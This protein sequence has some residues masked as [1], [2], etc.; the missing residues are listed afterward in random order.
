MLAN[1]I[2]QHAADVASAGNWPAVAERLNAKTVEKT[3]DGQLTS[4]GTV[5]IAL[6]SAVAEQ[7]LSALDQSQIG[8]SG[9]AK[10]ETSGLDFAHPLTV[11]LIQKLDGAQKLPIGAADQLLL[12]GRWKVAPAADAGLGTVTAEQCRAAWQ[13][14]ARDVFRSDLRQRFDVAVNQLWTPE[15][16][17]AAKD[18][19]LMADQI[20]TWQDAI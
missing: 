4:L 17:G 5:L 1:L 19:R 12:L 11:G 15:S 6:G 8:R 2:E 10:L 9:R 18:L 14:A 3:S 20:D 16:P 7:V 13:A